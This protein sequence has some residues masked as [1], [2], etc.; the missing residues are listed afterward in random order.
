MMDLVNIYA[1]QDRHQEMLKA[2]D[3]ERLIRLARAG[4]PSQLA[5]LRNQ[6][7]AMLTYLGKRLQNNTALRGPGR[8]QS[9]F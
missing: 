3:Q 2:A 1:N 4:Q 7:G 8:L 6:L 9:N 5:Q